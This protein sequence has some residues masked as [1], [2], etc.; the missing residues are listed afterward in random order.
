MTYF[1]KLRLLERMDGFLS[2]KR[3]GTAEEFAETLGICRR[4]VFYN[5]DTLRDMGAEIDF[6]EHQKS[7]F[8]VDDK[9]PH[10]PVISKS[11]SDKLRGGENFSNFF[12]GVQDFCTPTDD[13][14]SRLI[15]NEK[16]SGAGG[17]EF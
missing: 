9:R 7:Y 14:C 6:C 12:L 4:S 8:Y 13:L 1:D 5:F 15:N 17:F 2:R 16:Q 11:N 10:F 3:T